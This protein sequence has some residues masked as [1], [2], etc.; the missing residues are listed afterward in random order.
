MGVGRWKKLEKTKFKLKTDV[1]PRLE[2]SSFYL[3]F[4]LEKIKK[5]E[6]KA[7]KVPKK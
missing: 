3:F 7:E 2:R 6:W 4:F 1:A 5:R